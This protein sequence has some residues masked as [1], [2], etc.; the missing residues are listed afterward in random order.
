[1]DVIRSERHSSSVTAGFRS[2]LLSAGS[3]PDPPGCT[4]SRG[5]DD[6]AIAEEIEDFVGKLH[7]ASLR[8]RGHTEPVH[9]ILM[10]TLS[11]V[12]VVLAAIALAAVVVMLALRLSNSYL[13]FA[14]LVLVIAAIFVRRRDMNR[15]IVRQLQREADEA[16]DRGAD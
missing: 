5:S 8:P 7:Q 12:L 4:G 15:A 1:M 11:R 16:A 3:R 14:A 6:A 2:R 10:S 9:W 13:I